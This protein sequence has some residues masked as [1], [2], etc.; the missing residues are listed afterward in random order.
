MLWE[1]RKFWA[2]EP[3][4]SGGGNRRDDHRAMNIF[5]MNIFGRY[6]FRQSAGA[7]LL[8]L[9]S[10]SGVVWIALALRQLNLVT[11]EGQDTVTFLMMTTLALPNMMALIAPIALLVAVIHTLNRLSGD[12]ELII[13]TASGANIWTL[14]KPLLV[15]AMIVATAVAAVNHY[16]MPWSLRLL[17]DYVIQMRS[18]L[19]QQVLQPGRFS[20]PEAG[21]T[22]HIRDR[23]LNG[24]L[25]GLLMQD[26]RDPKVVTAYLAE[27]GSIIKRGGQSFL[28]MQTG[29]V[30]RREKK[31]EIGPP[32]PPQII[33]FDT[34]V[35]DLDRFEAKTGPVELKP[36]ERYYNELVNPREDD[37]D[38]KRQAGQY[39]AEL[40]ERFANPFYSFAFVLLAVAFI[41]QAQSTRT[42][43]TRTTVTAAVVTVGARMGG[44]AA[45][46][47]VVLNAKWVPV[48]YAIPIGLMVIGI[49]MMILGA[50]VRR[51]PSLSQR[52][53]GKI[54]PLF[55]RRPRSAAGA[56]G[57]LADAAKAGAR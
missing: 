24:E 29:H 7:L 53:F 11:T 49:V 50:R 46:N 47:L 9:L 20:S 1:P 26:A 51:G 35:V 18:N 13:L 45:N 4:R 48:L 21:L 22:F 2:R 27:H 5:G 41:G 12:S 33:E 8:I 23:S 3:R 39:R 43:R 14:A 36:R 6:V 44:L 28:L 57:A 19:I 16:G 30:L 17:R 56:I 32:E 52:L 10:L 54:P 38:A 31:A 25:Q 40:H 15:L 42:N 34:Y 37:P 55:A